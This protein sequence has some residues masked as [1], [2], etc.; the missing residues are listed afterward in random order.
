L[1]LHASPAPGQADAQRSAERASATR[2][3]WLHRVLLACGTVSAAIVVLIVL[4]VLKESWPA[5]AA[6]GPV[7]LISDP[8][9]HP[10]ESFNITPM[11]V[12]TLLSSLGAVVL[13]TP[14][15]VACAVF[16]RFY[17]PPLMGRVQRRVIEL[18]AGV[19]SVVY[20]FW[21]LVSLVPWLLEIAPP[22]Q[23]L[24]AGVLVLTIMIL[25]TVALMSDTAIGAVPT[26]VVH[27]AHALGF[28]RATLVGQVVLPAARAGIGTGVLLAAARALGETMAVLM[29]SGNVV[30][31][32]H[33]MLDPVRTLT[34]NI[35]LEMSYAMADHR[36]A[37]FA[38][39]L[40]LLLI[41]VVLV[42]LAE[43]FDEGIR[44]A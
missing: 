24:L 5:L 39:G 15:G 8:G 9:W 27:G 20:G 36:A 22:G 7:R 26:Q 30:Q 21:G 44:H 43:R 25:P 37:L 6:I 40:V 38:S 3:R 32:P 2:D 35:A 29:V 19:P 41:V 14:L 42:G 11:L 12:G 13:A 18:L 17:A 23:S 10:S 1:W 28:S 33:S 31:L 34:A 4:F 16:M